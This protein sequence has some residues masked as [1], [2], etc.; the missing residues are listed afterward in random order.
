[1]V[2]VPNVSGSDD[3]IEPPQGGSVEAVT[4]A[5]P[6]E[7]AATG[8][9]P[10]SGDAATRL[11]LGLGSRLGRGKHIA[12][13]AAALVLLCLLFTVLSPYFLSLEN[14]YNILLQAS[15]LAIVAAGLTVVILVGE[16]DLSVG[17]VEAL[18][19][20][21]AA[22]VMIKGHIPVVP[23][24]VLSLLAAV[25][26]GLVN[27][28]VTT[29][30]RVVSF[31]TTLAMLGVAQGVAFILTDGQAIEGFPYSF[32]R[33]GQATIGNG[34]FPVPAIIAVVAIALIYFLL[35][36]TKLGLHMFAVGGSR[37]AARFA[38]ISPVR[39]KTIAFVL[40]AVAS[41]IGG[42][43]LSSRLDAGNGLFGQNDLL[44]AVAAVVIGGASL[45]GGVGSVTGTTIGVLIIATIEDG[46]VIL[47][48]PD[49]WQQVVVGAFIVGAVM[50]DQIAKGI[51]SV[52][53]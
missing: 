24:V 18:V 38:G 23:G 47:N 39:I 51:A 48:V 4:I 10:R 29:K 30:L 17:S 53:E 27:A 19:G 37:D 44:N 52:E 34:G 5:P 32:G 14:F 25:L 6:G 2:A 31:I 16:I 45:S 49:F 40:C 33:I 15:N 22:I 8:Q 21:V 13:L 28:Y 3:M 41:G 7:A 46:L 11:L 9:T 36:H 50:I 26:V 20:S 35:S 43:I 12:G 42:L 1:M